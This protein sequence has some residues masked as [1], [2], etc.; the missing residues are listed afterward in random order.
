M[1]KLD[2]LQAQLQSSVNFFQFEYY[3][4][5]SKNYLI[6][7]LVPNA[8]GI[9]TLL[10]GRKIPMIPLLIHDNKFITDFKEKSEI[11][12]SFFSKQCSLIY[13][14]STLPSLFPLIIEKSLSDVDFSVED[15]KNI[16]SKLY[17]NQHSHA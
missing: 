12:N 4:K 14:G 1:I 11:F 5:I 6:H 13:N 7:P 8:I 15:I 3:R 10:N 9:K 2:A 16:I 17:S